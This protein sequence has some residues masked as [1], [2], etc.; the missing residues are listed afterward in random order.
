MG[1]ELLRFYDRW[2]S[3][4]MINL[5]MCGNHDILTLQKWAIQYFSAIKNKNVV[6]PDF[7]HPHPYAGKYVNKLLKWIPIK[8]K[9]T[10]TIQWILP[11]I[12]SHVAKADHL[13]YFAHLF[14]HEGSN[15][16]LSYL[17]KEGLALELASDGSYNLKCFMSFEVEITLTTKGYREYERVI[18]AVFQYA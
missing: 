6:P 5:V 8:E 14:G 17:I 12:S 18:L 16:L 10:L 15:S 7:S 9:H 4:N 1:E 13:K 3:A 11:Y 2:Y